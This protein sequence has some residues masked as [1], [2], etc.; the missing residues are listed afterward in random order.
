MLLP[1]KVRLIL[2]IWRYIF[3]AYVFIKKT[4]IGEMPE[5]WITRKRAQ[6]FYKLWC[7]HDI[8]SHHALLALC[9][10]NPPVTDIFGGWVWYPHR[11]NISILAAQNMVIFRY[12]IDT[13]LADRLM[14][15][16]TTRR[17]LRTAS[18]VGYRCVALW[19]LSHFADDIFKRIIVNENTWI[20]VICSLK[21]V[22]LTVF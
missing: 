2:D 9:A 10:G 8:E 11:C 19:R 17:E 22:Q 18:L 3:V 7:R 15:Y 21:F 14:V 6:E 13:H 20:S 1:T 4:L 12:I 5:W 16:S